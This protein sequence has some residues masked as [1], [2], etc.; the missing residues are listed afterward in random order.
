MD[1]KI[2]S[3]PDYE[4]DIYKK[5]Y[6]NKF[7]KCPERSENKKDFEKWLLTLILEKWN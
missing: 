6:F 1:I 7:A 2:K 5:Q 3:I 4:M